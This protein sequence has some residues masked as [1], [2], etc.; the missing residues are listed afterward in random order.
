M[1][2]LGEAAFRAAVRVKNRLRRS[3]AFGGLYR[4]LWQGLQYQQ[5]FTNIPVH[6]RMLGDAPRREAYQRAISRYVKPGDTVIDLGT[7]TGLLSFMAA[8]QDARKI[9]AID[10]ADIIDQARHVAMHNGLT[11]IEFTKTHSK[12]FAPGEKVDVIIQEQIGTHVFD[13]DMVTSV[14]DLRDRLL[15]PGGRILPNRFQVFVEP[16]QIKSEYRVPFLWEQRVN[17]VSYACLRPWYEREVQGD[18]AIG[19]VRPHQVDHLLCEPESVMAF[20]LMTV[21]NGTLPKTVSYRRRVLREGRLDGFCMYFRAL[22]DDEIV[23][24]NSP[25]DPQTNWA[26]PFMRTASTEL[27]KDDVL[28]FRMSFADL[29]LPRTWR[30]SFTVESAA[31]TGALAGPRDT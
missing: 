13:E 8:G 6:E 5:I 4:R 2:T 25:F 23:L 24:G 12:S 10:H 1:S 11:S 27:A 15:K 20:D 29:V 22:F 21:T 28:D 16:V 3:R 14:V 31:G 9:Y 7:G 17:G 30:W 19:Y 18:L 26:M